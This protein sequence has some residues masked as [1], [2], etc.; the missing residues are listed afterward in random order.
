MRKQIRGHHYSC[1]ICSIF[2]KMKIIFA[3]LYIFVLKRVVSIGIRFEAEILLRFDYK[4]NGVVKREKKY[5][6]HK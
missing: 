2:G 3:I 1:C 6:N 5:I 4:L